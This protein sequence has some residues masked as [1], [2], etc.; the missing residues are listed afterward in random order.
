MNTILII[1]DQ[2]KRLANLQRIIEEK[3]EKCTVLTAPGGAK[4]FEIARRKKPDAILIDT[5][6]AEDRKSVV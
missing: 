6:I 1:D 2:V 5:Q 3:F 4:G